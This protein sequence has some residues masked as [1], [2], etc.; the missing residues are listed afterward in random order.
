MMIRRTISKRRPNDEVVAAAV[1]V[2]E[3]AVDHTNAKD[4]AVAVANAKV[5]EHQVVV[6]AKDAG[7]V[8]VVDQ[9][10]IM[11]AAII[12]MPGLTI[13]MAEAEAVTKACH[14]EMTRPIWDTWEALKCPFK[15][16]IAAASQSI[17]P[18]PDIQH[19]P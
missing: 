13:I 1:V 9:A 12:T 3:E 16:I 4:V 15:I 11:A 18:G 6:G 7:A 10:A 8:V 17:I 19:Q 2:E 14:L 5:E